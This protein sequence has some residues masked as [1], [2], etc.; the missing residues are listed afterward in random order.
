MFM[1]PK[2]LLDEVR[3]LRIPVDFI[4]IFDLSNVP[5]YEGATELSLHRRLIQGYHS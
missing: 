1:F 3:A 4:E 2:C 5:Y